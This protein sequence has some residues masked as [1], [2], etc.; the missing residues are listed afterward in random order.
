MIRPI[1]KP[2]P[3]PRKIPKPLKS[4]QHRIPEY[5]RAFVYERTQYKCE[6][7]GRFGGRLDLHHRLARSQGGWDTPENLVAVDRLC[8][9]YIHAHPLEAKRRGFI[10]EVGK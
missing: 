6:W 10:V 9:S 1:S 7:C 5:L 2:I 8:H 4:T 3:R